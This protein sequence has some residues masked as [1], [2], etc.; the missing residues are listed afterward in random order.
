MI[1]EYHRTAEKQGIFLRFCKVFL[2]MG[3]GPPHF[4]KKFEQ[5]FDF[6]VP[7]G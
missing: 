6:L 5:A 1:K 2:L 7:G 4:L 3:E